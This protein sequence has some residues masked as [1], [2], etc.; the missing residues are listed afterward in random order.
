MIRIGVGIGLSLLLS[1]GPSGCTRQ[2]YRLD[3]DRESYQAL[4]EKLTQPEWALPN[5]SIDPPRESRLHDPALDT[6]HPP[7]PPD[8]PAAHEFMWYVDG[9]RSADW[10]GDGQA[11]SVESPHWR[12]S[13]G[14]SDAGALMLT[15]DR[16]VELAV[17]HSRE[18]Q[19]E[20]EDLYLTALALTLNRFEFDLQWFG[21]NSTI[22]EHFGSGSFPTE[23][24]T[25]TTA[26]NLG[27]SRA[28]A[29]GGQLLVDF[30]NSFVWEFAGPDRSTA[31]SNIG[32]NLI[33]PLLRRAGREVRLEELTQAERDLLYAVR[34]FARFRKQ[35]YLDIATSSYLSLL[36]QV[37]RI[38]NLEVNLVSLEQNLRVHDA[39][40]DAGIVSSVQVDQVF[41]SYQQGRLALLQARA[42]LETAIDSFNISLG[43]PPDV[44]VTLDDSLLAPFRLNEPALSELQDELDR[45]A[46]V[47]RERDAA[48][49]LDKLT[50]AYQQLRAFF[51][52]G[53]KL[54]D[55]VD[56]DL[57][58]WVPPPAPPAAAPLDEQAALGDRERAARE[59]LARQLTELRGDF[60]QYQ[61]DLRNATGGLREDTRKQSWDTLNKLARDQ[62][63]LLAQVFVVQ[64]Q[65]RVY[66]IKLPAI[67]TRQ[68]EAIA[69]ALTDRL[70]L[71]NARAQVV[72]AWRKIAVA[73]DGL[74]SGLDVVAGADIATEPGGSNPV[75]FSA[76]ASRYRV[77]LRF[78]GPLNRKAERNAYRT[79]LVTYQRARRSYMALEDRIQQSVRRDLRQLETDRLNFEI[80]RQSLI[81]AAR[82]VEQTRDEILLA[83]RPIDS[84]NTQ[85]VLNALNSL[86]QSKNALIS[87]YLSYETGRIRLLL[88]LEALQ[89]DERGVYVDESQQSADRPAGPAAEPGTSVAAGESAAGAEWRPA[90]L[91]ATP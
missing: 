14:L 62:A 1:L 91:G 44:T 33:Q 35:F 9:K 73:A 74:E 51:G 59:S 19:T 20:L 53:L 58:R 16:A 79:T 37:Q 12:D 7:M 50:E 81:A 75:K 87:I 11:D 27:F 60:D 86:L 56:A 52:R 29:T 23:T 67:T 30:A 85:D 78:D 83:D 15:P 82:Q 89:L 76:D 39:L 84:S 13:L 71:M 3:A 68:D 49:P 46:A 18:Y 22:F 55:V 36:Q 10:H 80:A 65:I 45:F 57:K 70:D 43:L 88:D 66:L 5:P 41:Q 17:L 61:R 2:H 26:S 42:D 77:G 21:R 90:G 34:S 28:F 63:T 47:Y 4:H 54:L 38:R 69:A 32:I 40:R 31:S 48:P 8:D 25:L 6:D 72:D 24:N 64:T